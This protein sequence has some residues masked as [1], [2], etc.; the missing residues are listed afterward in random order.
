MDNMFNHYYCDIISIDFENWDTS[1]VTSMKNMF[2]NCRFCDN[3]KGISSLNTSN[4]K[5]MMGMFEK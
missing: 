3:I 1:N 4:V 2:T 5:N